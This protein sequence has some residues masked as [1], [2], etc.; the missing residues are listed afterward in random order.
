[1]KVITAPEKYIM[2]ENEISVFLAGGITNCPDWQSNIIKELEERFD[3]SI[4]DDLVIF[5]PRRENFPIDKPSAAFEQIE[6]EFDNLSR[7]DIFSMYFCKGESDQPICMYELGRYISEMQKRFP[8]DWEER[9]IIS[10]E[11]GY[12]RAK[13]VIVQTG[14]ACGG[15]NHFINDAQPAD[16]MV[17]YYHETGII[18]AYRRLAEL[19]RT[20]R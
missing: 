16:D 1:M 8:I 15:K 5:N 9:I 17:R 20:G 19:K 14:L 3:S 13:D 18:G 11:K 12:K 2:Q 10:V 6:W 4:Y 7:M